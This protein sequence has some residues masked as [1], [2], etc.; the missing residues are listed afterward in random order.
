MSLPSSIFGPLDLITVSNFSPSQI[1]IKD[2]ALKDI[3]E[4]VLSDAKKL[5]GIHI[6]KSNVLITPAMSK[7]DTK[8]S[9]PNVRGDLTCWVTPNL[10]KDL[11]LEYFSAFIRRLISECKFFRAHGDLGL[12]SDYSVQ[13]AL[14]VRSASSK[15]HH[16]LI[17]LCTNS[18]LGTDLDMCVIWM[19]TKRTINN[20]RAQ[21]SRVVES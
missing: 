7:G 4:G 10:C 19:L 13:F 20:N 8:W 3:A 17:F 12:T 11:K 6:S 2:D 5:V 16:L 1:L 15:F 21:A 9:N 18:S 14:Y